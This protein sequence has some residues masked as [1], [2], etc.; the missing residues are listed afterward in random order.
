MVVRYPVPH[1]RRVVHDDN[2]RDLVKVARHLTSGG[3]QIMQTKLESGD[4][5][6][7]WVDIC[8]ALT[9][10]GNRYT[11]GGNDYILILGKRHDDD[12]MTGKVMQ[13]IGV[14]GTVTQAAKCGTF[15]IESDGEVTRWPTGLRGL[16]AA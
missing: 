3:V 14:T 5:Y 9:G 15:R 13:V 6:R 7:S 8:T 12:T 2:G 16:V 4:V 10:S 11:V 1:R